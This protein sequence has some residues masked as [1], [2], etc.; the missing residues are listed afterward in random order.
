MSS[1]SHRH[2]SGQSDPRRPPPTD[3]PIPA[4][5]QQRPAQQPALRL[6]QLLGYFLGLGTWGFGGPIATVGYMQR[7]L[8]ERRRWLDRQDFLDG[9][10]LGQTMP[11]P[12]AAQVA[13]WVG[14]LSRG[15]LGALAVAAAFIIPSFVAVLAVAVVYVHAQ[16]L[17]VV[18]ARSGTRRG[19]HRP[20]DSPSRP[21]W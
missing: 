7:D 14:F 10:A 11:G 17:P 20:A 3:Q 18:Q 16:G 19:R 1:A 5:Q 4:S 8:V 2:T 9:V 15:A 12:L 6:R 21:W 13:M